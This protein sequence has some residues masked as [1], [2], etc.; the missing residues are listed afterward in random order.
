MPRGKPIPRPIPKDLEL[1]PFDG[2]DEGNRVEPV[3][4]T[5][6]AEFVPVRVAE[7]VGIAAVDPPVEKMVA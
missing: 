5:I 4:E 3:E 1:G 6:G 2:C 7:A